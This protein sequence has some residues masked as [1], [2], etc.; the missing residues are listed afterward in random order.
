MKVT[1]IL[2]LLFFI[3]AIAQAQTP[4]CYLTVSNNS[5]KLNGS[6]QIYSPRLSGDQLRYLAHGSHGLQ[7]I[8]LESKEK[9][10]ATIMSYI[11]AVIQCQ[12]VGASCSKRID[13]PLSKTGGATC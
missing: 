13:L 9:A 6:T 10:E 3:V 7:V 8:R 12:Q 11:D 5:T 2:V 4:P 1:L